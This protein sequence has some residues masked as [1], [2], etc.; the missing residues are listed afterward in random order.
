[1]SSVGISNMLYRQKVKVFIL[2][3][4]NLGTAELE[5]RRLLPFE[6]EDESSRAALPAVQCSAVQCSAVHRVHE[7]E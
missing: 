7:K 1:V 6:E 4:G 2:I 3:S 5:G